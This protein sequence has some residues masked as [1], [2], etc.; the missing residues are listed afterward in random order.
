MIVFMQTG[1]LCLHPQKLWRRSIAKDNPTRNQVTVGD[2]CVYFY[3]TVHKQSDAKVGSLWFLLHGYS[4]FKNWD[5]FA[6]KG[7]IPLDHAF[8]QLYS[9]LRITS[10]SCRPGCITAWL[11]YQ[12]VCQCQCLSSACAASTIASNYK[13]PTVKICS[14]PGIEGDIFTIKCCRQVGLKNVQSFK[15]FYVRGLCCSR[16]QTPFCVCRH[17]NV[18]AKEKKQNTFSLKLGLFLHDDINSWVTPL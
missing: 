4:T 15:S 10:R 1:W 12:I 8:V 14:S 7:W 11:L 17:T 9:L 16:C 5:I 6:A 18:F 2:R 3:E 13:C